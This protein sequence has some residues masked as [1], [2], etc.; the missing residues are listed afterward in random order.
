MIIRKFRD[1]DIG[2]LKAWLKEPHVAKWFTHPD[3]WIEEI[4]LRETKFSFIQHY[5]VEEEG[6]PIGFCQFYDYSKGGE[7]WNGSIP[8][9]GSY[10]IDYL[11][12]DPAYLG[13][14]YGTEIVKLL[15]AEIRNKTDAKRIIVK[16]EPE[17]KRSR[18]TLISAGFTYD[19]K[20]DLY[21]RYF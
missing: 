13:K 5:V 17:N 15:T 14:G 21:C 7:E 18:S 12:G 1:W 8:A 6:Y 4:E 2:L 11:I 20:N 16:P 19:E 10:S 9:E 3:A